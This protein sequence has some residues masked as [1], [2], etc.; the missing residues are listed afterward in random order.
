MNYFSK[1]F[2][3]LH[4]SGLICFAATSALL[5]AGLSGCSDSGNTKTVSIGKITTV[6]GTGKFGYSGDGGLATAA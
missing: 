1:H 3:S 5:V 2:R 6:A 4:A